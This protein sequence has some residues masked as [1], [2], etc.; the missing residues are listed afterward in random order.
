MDDLP[1][2]YWKMNFKQLRQIPRVWEIVSKYYEVAK[3]SVGMYYRPDFEDL[4]LDELEYLMRYDMGGGIWI[5]QFFEV[6][7]ELYDMV[8][9]GLI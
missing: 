6:K 4:I 9:Y 3:L 2:E 7:Q 1:N 8:H 5:G